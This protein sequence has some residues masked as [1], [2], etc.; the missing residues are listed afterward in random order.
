MV[1][2]AQRQRIVDETDGV[3]ADAGTA[4][5]AS[6]EEVNELEEATKQRFAGPSPAARE[7]FEDYGKLM[8]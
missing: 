4:G 5:G 3:T 1:A 6:D 8:R 7:K 2:Y